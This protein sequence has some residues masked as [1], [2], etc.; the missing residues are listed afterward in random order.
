FDSFENEPRQMRFMLFDANTDFKDLSRRC[1]E[2]RIAS[3]RFQTLVEKAKKRP[4]VA[5][6]PGTVFWKHNV[7]FKERPLG[8]EPPT[9]AGRRSRPPASLAAAADGG[10][11]PPDD[12]PTRLLATSLLV[13]R[14]LVA[15]SSLRA[16]DGTGSMPCRQ[17]PHSTRSLWLNI[18]K[19]L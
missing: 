8:G 7:Y 14:S 15:R 17:T 5:E 11:L 18:V 6:L 16:A 3:G 1:R 19:L 9:D 13:R 4:V 10:C 12:R 2:L